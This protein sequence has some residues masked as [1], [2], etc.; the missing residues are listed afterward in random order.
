M[1]I[2]K[3]TLQLVDPVQT[4][5]V[6]L[7]IDHFFRSLAEDQGEKAVCIILSGTGTD[8]T[9]WLKA[10]K[11][12]GGMAMAQEERQAQYNNMPKSAIDTG[13]V[14]FILPVENM[15][16]ELIRY[17]KHPY[18]KAPEKA[19]GPEE[20][21]QS[22]LSK[23]FLLVR[24]ATGHD[25]SSYKQGTTRRRVERRMAV[26][27]ID[28]IEDYLH[29]LQQNCAEIIVLD[30]D[31]Y[32]RITNF[33]RDP[34]AF[35]ALKEKVILP[36]LKSKELE[37]Q[38]RIWVPGCAS[39][40]EAYSIAILCAEAMEELK[41]HLDIQIFASDIDTE[42]IESAR[43]AVYPESIAADVSPE[44]LKRFFTKDETVYKVNKQ[45]RD[46]VVFAIQNLIKD[47][48]F[49]KLELVSCRNLLI[50]MDPDLQKRILPLFHYVLNREG[51]LFSGPSESIGAFADLF[52]PVDTKWKIFTRKESA[53][54]KAIEYLPPPFY[55]AAHG[56]TGV[57]DKSMI[58]DGRIRQ[59]AER[60][61]LEDYAPPSVLIDGNSNVLYFHGKTDLF[62]IAAHRGSNLQYPKHDS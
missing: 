39:G 28:N 16:D 44:R 54:K 26:H 46:R 3:G 59:F 22:A 1:A 56:R 53:T 13:L 14:D 21:F 17:A 19:V 41:K 20:K 33:F 51:V 10:I 40:E 45:I 49:S 52:M 43:S 35:E 5:V 50:Y 47:P 2:L 57:E 32:I 30:K 42:A 48:P 29:Y 15:S 7:P 38:V 4:H 11:G 36:L 31:L 27:Q 62:F 9:L 8:G 58:S 61:I 37:T 18:I 6:R 34:H 23:I 60:V 25:F 12:T 24:G 55:E